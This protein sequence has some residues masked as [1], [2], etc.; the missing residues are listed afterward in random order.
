MS[1]SWQ[2]Q[3]TLTLCSRHPV[4]LVKNVGPLGTLVGLF[5]SEGQGWGDWGS[6]VCRL[7]SAYVRGHRL[8]I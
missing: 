3:P 1:P 2:A 6:C 7:H 4:G 8:G 5:K